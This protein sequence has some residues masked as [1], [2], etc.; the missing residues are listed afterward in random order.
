L[1]TR[2][3]A[4]ER[5]FP[6]KKN[7]RR[8]AEYLQPGSHFVGAAL[9]AA[10]M[11]AL[12]VPALYLLWPKSDSIAVAALGTY[13]ALAKSKLSPFGNEKPEELVA[14]LVHQVGGHLHPMGYDFS[15]VQMHPVAGSVQ[16]IHGRKVLVVI[17]RGPGGTLFCYTF[18]GSEAD[19][20]T[21]AA[22]FY[23]PAKKM[24]LYA[25]SGGPVNAVLHREN[26]LICILASEMPMNDLLELTRSKARPS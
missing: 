12:A 7:I 21:H 22:K 9:A 19:A 11:L 25:F 17:Y 13:E 20:P 16:E 8:W 10:V 14:R 18:A 1:R 2:I 5:I 26:D 23:D 24:N 6:Q 3:L 4:D 15:R